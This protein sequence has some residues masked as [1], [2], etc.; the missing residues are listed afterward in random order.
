ML[1]HRRTEAFFLVLFVLPVFAAVAQPALKKVKLGPQVNSPAREIAPMISAD[2]CTLYFTREYYIDAEVRERAIAQ[3]TKGLDEKSRAQ[4]AAILKSQMTDDS[5]RSFTHQTIWFSEKQADGTWGQA[6]KMTAP[7]NNDFPSWVCSA[8]PDNNTLLVGGRFGPGAVK[9]EYDFVKEMEKIAKEVGKEAEKGADLLTIMQKAKSPQGTKGEKPA[10][11][12]GAPAPVILIV[13]LTL[14]AGDRWSEPA[15]LKIEGFSTYSN[16]NDFFLAP[17]NRVL[18]LSIENQAGPGGRDLFAS[19]RKA[20][21]TWSQPQPLGPGVN[22]VQDEISPFVAADGASLY[23]ASNRKEGF[24]GYDIYLSRRQDE[25][26]LNWSPAQT[27]GP[28]LNTNEEESNLTVDGMGRYA[29]LSAGRTSAEDIYV[30]DLA[31]EMRPLPVAFVFGRAHDPA[32]KPVAASVSY[33]RLRDGVGAGEANS[34]RLSG[35]YRIGLAIG[36]SYGFRAEAAGYIPVSDRIDLTKARPG[37]E[38]QRDLLLIPIKP[39]ATIRLN[40]LFF[41]FA[42]TTLLPESGVELKRLLAILQQYPKMEIEIA[43]HTD[44]VG[45][46]RSNQLLSEGRAA[47]VLKYLKEHGVAASRLKSRGCGESVPVVANDTDEHR[48]LNRRVEFTILKME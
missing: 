14:R 44:N 18:I 17:G 37:E 31:P 19:F 32:D 48:Q 38:F 2:G 8:L 29:F 10:A 22:G 40:N 16:R 7:L 15:Y 25:T 43:G 36:E 28:E 11:P 47:A 4:T 23:F 20:D 21:G 35:K 42:K 5:F 1:T 27:L 34:D 41:E 9:Q 3:L 39:G 30:F 24:G 46:D 13:A 45:D 33:E 26:W 12:A 6:K